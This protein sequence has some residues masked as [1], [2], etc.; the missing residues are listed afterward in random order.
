MKKFSV[1][2][3]MKENDIVADAILGTVGGGVDLDMKER[4]HFL[5]RN[6]NEFSNDITK[7]ILNLG[8]VKSIGEI[9]RNKFIDIKNSIGRGIIIKDLIEKI[10]GEDLAPKARLSL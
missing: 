2:L 6:T 4:Q 1:W 3:E 10:R 9:D 8:I 7:K 5:Q